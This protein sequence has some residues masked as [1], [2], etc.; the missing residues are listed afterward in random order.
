M[1]AVVNNDMRAQVAP[2]RQAG[3]PVAWLIGGETCTQDKA[4]ADDC[5]ARGF[6]VE[7]F[8]ASPQ[9]ADPE[10]VTDAMV[11]ALNRFE[12]AA[13]AYE[14]LGKMT[15]DD[16]KTRAIRKDAIAE[17]AQSRAA[18][19]AAIGTGGQAVAVKPLEWTVSNG[20][21]YAGGYRVHVDLDG[22]PALYIV[23]GW[24]GAGTNP[25]GTLDEAQA[26]AQANHDAYIRSCLALS[27]PHPADERVVE[28]LRE[29]LAKVAYVPGDHPIVPV[30]HDAFLK[31][32]QKI[33]DDATKEGR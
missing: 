32:I 17:L 21:W 23:S 1:D 14:R 31:T 26:A 8:Y 25:Y 18:L 20:D 5:R 28:A 10:Q 15:R 16:E 6:M 3:E 27:Q 30:K 4:K 7:S 2:Q 22:S 19:A 13:M 12:R 24:H 11:E 29:A 33:V 9:P